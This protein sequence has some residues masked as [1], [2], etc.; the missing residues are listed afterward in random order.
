MRSRRRILVA[1]LG[2]AVLAA[3]GCTD[4]PDRGPRPVAL[5]WREVA[6]PFPPGPPGRVAVRDA[7]HCGD[8]WYVTGAVFGTDGVTRPAAW[9]STDGSAWTGI[10]FTFTP[11]S[12]YGRRSIVYAVGCRGGRIAAIGARSGGAH[13]NPRVRTWAQRPDG[14]LT[15]VDADF[16]VYGGPKAV[17]VS[18]IAGGLRGWLIA[19]S[20]LSGTAVW[21]SSDA[22]GFRVHEGV[23]ELASDG[24]GRTW[25]IDALADGAGWLVVGAVGASRGGGADPMVW[26][27]PDGAAWRR[28][29]V[30]A[31]PVFDELHR[32]ARTDAG[33]VAV[34][35][36]GTAFGA[37]L[38]GPDGGWRAAGTF[39]STAGAIPP[40]V[41]GL[42]VG[43]D[44]VL[45]ATHAG[46]GHRLWA[47][48]PAAADW[49][50]V[51]LPVPMTTTHGDAAMTIAAGVGQ[52]LLLADD[53]QAGRVWIAPL[54]RGS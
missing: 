22:T 21:T 25:A 34:G 2:V 31:E 53:A 11:D 37:W 6:L 51:A 12:Y 27:S 30:P 1:L 24:R 23:P 41:D 3:G 36:R 17:S 49:A 28:L 38:A 48:T 29:A 42:A 44:V 9:T 35:R 50:P 4:P 20:R 40:G 43:D 7:T 33:L 16:E 39:G 46:D 19:G 26:V 13:G 14:S 18:R 32:V 8:R 45:V 47:S 15:E 10:G 54:R 52:A 5:D